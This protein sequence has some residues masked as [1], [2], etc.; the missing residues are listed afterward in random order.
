MPSTEFL[1]SQRSQPKDTGI[2]AQHPSGNH[3]FN[4]IRLVARRYGFERHSKPTVQITDRD[5]FFLQH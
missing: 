4:N 3:V 1:L 2:Q 5:A